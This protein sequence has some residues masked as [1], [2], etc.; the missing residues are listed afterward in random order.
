MA[1]SELMEEIINAAISDGIIS[2]KE[3]EVLYKKAQREGIDPDELDIILEARLQK[4]QTASTQAPLT[5]PM[6]A[7]PATPKVNK[8]PAC[9]EVITDFTAICP[10]CGSIVDIKMPG[11]RELSRLMGEMEDELVRLRTASD[12]APHKARLEGLVRQAKALY[13][14]NPKIKS[15]LLEIEDAIGEQEKKAKEDIKAYERQKRNRNLGC[16]GAVALI[17][18]LVTVQDM[19]DGPAKETVSA[20]SGF[21]F[22]FLMIYYFYFRRKFNKEDQERRRR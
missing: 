1:L 21:V 10:A 2:D 11:A 12:Y 14:S 19:V 6:P 17:I 16:L 22:I 8:C 20:I 9:G 3:R 4:A 18:V 7:E 5:P 13:G 15:L